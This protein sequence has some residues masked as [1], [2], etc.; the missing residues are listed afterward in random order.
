MAERD[1]N[2]RFVKGSAGGPGRPARATEE[3]FMVR[4]TEKLTMEDWDEIVARAVQDAKQ[5]DKDA[6]KWL[7]EHVLGKPTSAAPTASQAHERMDALDN[8]AAS[9]VQVSRRDEII[10]EGT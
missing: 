3:R 10:K 9:I 1:E 4:L 2:G 8:P 7:A 5:G 6:R